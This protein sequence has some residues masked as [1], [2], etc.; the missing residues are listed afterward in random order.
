[1]MHE[2][3]LE[4]ADMIALCATHHGTWTSSYLGSAT[5]ALAINSPVTLLVAKGAVKRSGGFT[6]VLANDHSNI[7]QRWIDH[8]ISFAPQGITNLHVVSAYEVDDEAAAAAHKN[9]AMLGG[10]VERWLNETIT[11]RTKVT[12][13]KLTEAG[14]NTTF[15]V[16]EGPATDAIRQ[17][18]QEQQADILIIGAHGNTQVPGAK[19]G[20][21][22]LHQVVAETYPLLIIR[23]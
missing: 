2:A 19:I 12:A 11:E 8:F 14:F 4:N 3:E 22:A 5:C 1:M 21:V 17:A 18:M 15:S 7:S 16:K 6:A 23:P 9:L 20:S 10:D 13:D